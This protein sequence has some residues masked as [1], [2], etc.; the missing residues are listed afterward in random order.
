MHKFVKAYT[1]TYEILTRSF[2]SLKVLPP[3]AI[4][5]HKVILQFTKKPQS[6]KGHNFAKIHTKWYLK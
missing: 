5:N 4:D 2:C 3:F 1:C 6:T